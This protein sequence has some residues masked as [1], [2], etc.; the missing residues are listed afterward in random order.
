MLRLITEKKKILSVSPEPLSPSS[1]QG[2]FSK[3]ENP[4]AVM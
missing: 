4:L 2:G 1:K 3:T